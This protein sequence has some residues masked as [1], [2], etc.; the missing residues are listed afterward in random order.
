MNIL[1]GFIVFEGLDGAGTTTQTDLLVKAYQR[2]GRDA[3]GKDPMA[4]APKLTNPELLT[5]IS[6]YRFP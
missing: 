6:V 1:Q 4:E 2:T 3:V 5:Q